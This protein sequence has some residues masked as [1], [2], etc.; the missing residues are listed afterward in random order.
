M[1]SSVED[2]FEK[3][4][5]RVCQKKRCHDPTTLTLL[6]NL[7]FLSR[8]TGQ[9]I[10]T[11]VNRR[12]NGATLLHWAVWHGHGKLAWNLIHIACADVNARDSDGRTPLDWM[13][14]SGEGEIMS[15]LKNV[16]AVSKRFYLTLH[17]TAR[18]DGTFEVIAYSSGGESKGSIQ[19]RQDVLIKR[20]RNGFANHVGVDAHDITLILDTGETRSQS[21]ELFAMDDTFIQAIE[22][23]SIPEQLTGIQLTRHNT[24]GVI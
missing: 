6:D 12:G 20:I 14:H 23:A 2:A 19:C 9:D 4:S 11:V 17:P 13:E 24:P 3:L 7:F 16:G 15:M 5:H 8:I 21:R 18:P 22:D 10:S 1:A